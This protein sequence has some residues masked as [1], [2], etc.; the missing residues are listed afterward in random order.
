[1]NELTEFSSFTNYVK[2]AIITTEL[3]GFSMQANY[4]HRATDACQRS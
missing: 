2:G 1:M 3:R 4:T